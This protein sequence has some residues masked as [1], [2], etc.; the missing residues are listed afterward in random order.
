MNI[1]VLVSAM[2][3]T[4]ADIYKQM[5]LHTDAVIV[6]QHDK[7]EVCNTSINGKNVLFITCTDRG[8][9]KS[10]NRA[11][12]S[13][14]ADICVFADEDMTFYDNYAQ[15]ISD[16]FAKNSR[17]EAILFNI[18]VKN[19]DRPVEKISKS[20]KMT[21][22]D[23]M[24]YGIPALAVKREVLYKKNISFSLLFGGGATYGSGEDTI[25]FRDMLKNK[26]NVYISDKKIAVTDAADSSWFKGFD[27]KFFSDKGALY[28]AMF[29]KKAYITSIITAYRWHRKLGNNYKFRHIFKNMTN[30]IQEFLS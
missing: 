15:I 18:D 1:E 21:L 24:R 13:S 6:N 7:N 11:V 10:R 14:T 29:G 23:A 22:R 26:M 12:M 5:N 2:Y 28:A 30:G 3:R 4:D 9:G 27:D 19:A 20:K 25:F 8:V 17:A 16:E